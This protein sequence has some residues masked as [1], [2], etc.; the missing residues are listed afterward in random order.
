[1]HG[2]A[3]RVVYRFHGAKGI[4]APPTKIVGCAFWHSPSALRYLNARLASMPKA[5]AALSPSAASSAALPT[6]YE[7]GLQELEQLVA[8][9]ESG[10]LPLDELLAGYQRGAELLKLCRSKLDAVEQQV[11]VLDDGA[12]RPWTQE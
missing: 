4:V 11:R 9:L 3:R 6:S 8:Q 1:M 5:A 2:E 10:Q 7:A 12:L